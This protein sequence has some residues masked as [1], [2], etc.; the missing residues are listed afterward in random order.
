MNAVYFQIKFRD[1]AARPT[2]VVKG[3]L[4]SA[5]C[6][7]YERFTGRQR[8]LVCKECNPACTATILKRSPRHCR[9]F[10]CEGWLR[11]SIKYTETLLLLLLLLFR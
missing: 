6:W 5:A 3:L 8:A 9:R 10:E 11:Q 1:L 4:C 7:L 2:T